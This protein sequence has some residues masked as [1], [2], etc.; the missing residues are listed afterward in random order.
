[1]PRPPRRGI[2]L[3]V[4]SPVWAMQRRTHLTYGQDFRTE[5]LPHGGYRSCWHDHIPVADGEFESR[6]LVCRGRSLRHRGLLVA[7]RAAT[8]Q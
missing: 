7:G 3:F 5:R 8:V 2:F 1:M 6:P 4:M